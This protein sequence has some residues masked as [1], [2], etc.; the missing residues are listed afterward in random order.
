MLL[1]HQ[2]SS[3]VVCCTHKRNKLS[4]RTIFVRML[5]TKVQT[6]SVLPFPML[7]QLFSCPQKHL[8][9]ICYHILQWLAVC[10]YMGIIY[11]TRSVTRN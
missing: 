4:C 5:W 1:V 8:H 7:T 2:I 3:Y 10:Y 11:A 6:L 9:S